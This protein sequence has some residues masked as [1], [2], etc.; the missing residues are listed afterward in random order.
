MEDRGRFLAATYG[1][2]VT[3]IDLSVG[4][5]LVGSVPTGQSLPIN[6][7]RPALRERYA[8]LL[9]ERLGEKRQVQRETWATSGT[10]VAQTQQSLQAAWKLSQSTVSK[11]LADLERQAAT[12]PGRSPTAALNALLR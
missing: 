8:T 10:T 9:R 7:L 2:R 11:V 4:R 12:F 6:L 5:L 3:G 1:S